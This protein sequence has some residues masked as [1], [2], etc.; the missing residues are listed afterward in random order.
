M[1]V[2]TLSSSHYFSP[3]WRDNPLA[4]NVGFGPEAKS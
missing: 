1:R 4:T 2:L 3:I